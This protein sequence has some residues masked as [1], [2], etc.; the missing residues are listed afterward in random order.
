VTAWYGFPNGV[1]LFLAPLIPLAWYTGKEMYHRHK[2]LGGILFLAIPC[3][4]LAIFFAKSTG[5]MIG[6]VAWI[7]IT[8]LIYKKTRYVTILLTL[9][10]GIALMTMDSLAGIRTELLFQDRSGQIRQAIYSETMTFLKD[11][12]LLGA[13]IGSYEERIAPYHQTVNGESIEIYHHPHNIFLTMWVNIGLLGLIGF[14]GVLVYL[15]RHSL[16]F[17]SQHATSP[18]ST[19]QYSLTLSLCVLLITGLVDSPYIK[20]DLA[21]L[22]WTLMTLCFSVTRVD[23]Q[24]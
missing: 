16:L 10:C 18:L 8:L 22:A 24:I 12:P 14:I 15:A 13:G 19:I 2:L 7:G 17:F 4:L 20:N 1:G 11:R 5:A 3:S 6:V 23:T 21:F 9:L